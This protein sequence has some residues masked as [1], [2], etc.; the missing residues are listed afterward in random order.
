M[1]TQRLEQFRDALLKVLEANN[2]RFGLQAAALALMARQFGFSATE[3][4]AEDQLEYLTE[5]GMAAPV[6]KEMNRAARA[7]KITEA[8][9]QYL[10]EHG[11]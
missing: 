8:G 3:A 11:L 10:D 5:K 4:E 2:T 1:N 7:W 9:R 6:A